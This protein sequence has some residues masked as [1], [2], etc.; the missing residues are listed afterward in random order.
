MTSDVDHT[1]PR[2]GG[3]STDSDNLAH[4]CEPHHR[5]KHLSQW[6]VTQEPGGILHWTSPGKR[7]YR[8]DPANPIGPPR[9]RPPVA[10]P[11]TRKRPA[12]ETYLTPRQRPTRHPT[13]PVPE[14]PPF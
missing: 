3:G 6:R 9:P 14:N 8:T 1:D 11:K 4:L 10:G 12:D 13:P 2:A 5:L 7:S